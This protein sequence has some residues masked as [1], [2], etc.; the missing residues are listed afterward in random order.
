MAHASADVGQF[1][2]DGGGGVEAVAA[3]VLAN[4][5]VVLGLGHQAQVADSFAN[6]HVTRI[7]VAHRLSTIRRADRVVVLDKGRIGQPGAFQ[8]LAETPGVFARM[9]AR[10]TL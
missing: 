9:V 8:E 4:E 3:A 6:L 2:G 1:G 5:V 10:Q 7:V